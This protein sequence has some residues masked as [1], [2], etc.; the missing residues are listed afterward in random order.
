MKEKLKMKLKEKG[1]GKAPMGK[2][3]G[4]SKMKKPSKPMGY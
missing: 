2:V 4:P 1:G 3:K